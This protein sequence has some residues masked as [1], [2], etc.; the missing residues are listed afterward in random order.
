MVKISARL[1]AKRKRMIGGP[2]SPDQV[3]LDNSR[4]E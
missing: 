1:L 3:R 4:W 2:G